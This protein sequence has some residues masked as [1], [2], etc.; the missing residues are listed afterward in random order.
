MYRQPI[1]QPGAP[2]APDH[3]FGPSLLA[4]LTELQADG[5]SDVSIDRP[6]GLP[7]Y[8]ISLTLEG[9]GH[10]RD[11]ALVLEPAPGDLLLLPPD[12]PQFFRRAEGQ[13]VWRHRW[14]YFQARGF[15]AP[16]LQWQAGRSDS[17][18]IGRLRPAAERLPEFDALL[19][20]IAAQRHSGKG[21]AEELAMNTLERLL[22]CCHEETPG[23]KLRHLD[24]RVQAACQYI[25]KHLDQDLSLQQIAEHACLSVSRLAHVFREH[26]GLNIV[27][28][29]EDQRIL[30]AKH[31]LG[32]PGRP[33]SSIAAR[34]GYD[35]HLYFSRVFR[36]RVG[37]SP[38]EYRNSTLGKSGACNV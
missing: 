13:A 21:M 18:R 25:A 8:L 16:W 28:W 12:S 33:I 37:V 30:L 20:E 26:T 5:R 36:K 32:A 29:R 9:G 11:G 27:R 38:S 2:S 6:Q 31:M 24:P 7:G 4:G 14:V 35:D 19:R 3:E 34:V 22:I 10:V 15:W 17:G 23:G 1:G